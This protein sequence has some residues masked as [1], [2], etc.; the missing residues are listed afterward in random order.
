MPVCSA[1]PIFVSGFVTSPRETR[2]FIAAVAEFAA[3]VEHGQDD[4]HGG[5]PAFVHVHGDAAAVIHDGDAVVPVDGHFHMVAVARQRLVDGVVHHLVNEMVQAALGG[6]ADV[7][8][9]PHTNGLQAFEDLDLIGVIGAGHLGDLGVHHVRM[10]RDARGVQIGVF[11]IFLF[12]LF[13]RLDFDF[14][15]RHNDPPFPRSYSHTISNAF[16][17]SS[18]LFFRVPGESAER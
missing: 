1:S 6:A 12:R 11:Q 15:F 4:L 8:A 7:H 3:G 2:D 18:A 13:L 9:R 16:S 14:V 17:L 5:F 10:D